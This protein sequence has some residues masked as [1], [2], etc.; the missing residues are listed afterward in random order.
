M[1]K[2]LFYSVAIASTMLFAACSNEAPTLAP[3]K[4]LADAFNAD[5]SACMT[6]TIAAPTQ[7]VSAKGVIGDYGD[8]YGEFNNGEA[9]EH[10]VETA[11]L[12]LFQGK[13]A[14]N[15]DTYT[16]HSA[17]EL[18]GT[19]WNE[20]ESNPQV[21]K[22]GTIVAKIEKGN[23]AEDEN[24][25][26][27]VL[28]NRHQYFEVDAAT[29]T[30][31]NA[32]GTDLK[33]Q[34]LA[35]FNASTIDEQ[36]RNFSAQS[37]FMTNMPYT[38]VGGG[39]A[40]PTGAETKVLYPVNP[41]SIYTSE[42]DALA[43]SET[44]TINVER[45]LAKVSVTSAA[46]SFTTEDGQANV[47]KVLGWFIDNTNKR[48]SVIRNT[49]ETVNGVYATSTYGYLQYA[50]Q[51]MASP[52]YRFVS[53][54][55]VED[56]ADFEG[57]KY[58]R[59]F[60]AIDHNYMAPVGADD[61]T[62]KAGQIVVNEL[63]KYNDAGQRIEGAG[64]LRPVG[65][66]YYCTEN[67]FDIVHQSVKNTTRVVVAVQFNNGNDFYT[68]TPGE[69]GKI[70]PNAAA[71]QNEVLAQALN[72]VRAAQ[73]LYDYIN[74]DSVADAKTL[75]TVNLDTDKATGTAKASIELKQLSQ[76]Q[77]K[78]G[79]TVAGA[80]AAWNDLATEMATW[81][82][83]NI[84]INYF[85]GGVCYY[86]AL[87]QHFGKNET[88]WADNGEM[89]NNNGEL[90]VYG[91]SSQDYLGRYGVVRNNWYKVNITGVRTIGSSVVPPLT[92]D[93]PDD[94]VERYIKVDINI[95]PWAI[96]YQDTKL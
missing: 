21:T 31:K 60:W 11:V 10:T 3:E 70:Y 92:P 59:T 68:V 88:P 62:T 36:N 80:T 52:T 67:T 72:R 65:G 71:L 48:T 19:Q 39:N 45:V 83:A 61:L 15:E 24:L 56:E 1:K 86:S 95:T 81:I 18:K 25:Y 79:K 94:Q 37:F 69:T 26:A 8:N 9:Y 74:G 33:G 29:N 91:V 82:H 6:L 77:L 4:S 43:G 49:K 41:K 57:N 89:E 87:I 14:A 64:D 51:Q 63:M 38:T 73:W 75:F 85:E 42:T 50:S 40:A 22:S 53:Q 13:S 35:Q 58:Y 16:L 54:K 66:Y 7:Q 34:T 90:G 96:R 2:G 28:I 46:P 5:G 12:V 78:T 20:R 32:A 30:L 27:M 93:V 44:T 84:N 55:P 47:G 23:L 17:Y 76:N